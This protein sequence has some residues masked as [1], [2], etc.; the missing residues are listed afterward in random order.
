MITSVPRTIMSSSARCDVFFKFSLNVQLRSTLA[1]CYRWVAIFSVCI[2]VAFIS[3]PTNMSTREYQVYNP[4]DIPQSL[5]TDY[6]L[7]GCPG[8]L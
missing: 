2:L 4:N 8:F 3:P 7:P 6:Q 5:E 1:G